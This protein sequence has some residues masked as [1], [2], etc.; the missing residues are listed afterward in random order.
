[1][2]PT[3]LLPL[4]VA[5]A[6]VPRVD[7]RPERE[8][9]YLADLTPANARSLAGKQARYRVV[10]DS[11]EDEA[12]R[13][14]DCVAPDGLHASVFLLPDQEAADMMTAEA[15]LVIIDHPASWGFPA[16]SE[17][18]LGKF[19]QGLCRRCAVAG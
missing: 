12:T 6:D 4:T 16:L 9:Y 5:L 15:R 2:R 14:Y 13:S 17:Y 7:T 19:G 1:M 8:V 3:L 10:L 18:R 11:L